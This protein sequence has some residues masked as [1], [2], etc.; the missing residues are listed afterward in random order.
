MGMGSSEPGK[1]NH[2]HFRGAFVRPVLLVYSFLG[3]LGTLYT[4]FTEKHILM[5]INNCATLLLHAVIFTGVV[6]NTEPALRFCRKFIKIFIILYSIAFL[7]MPVMVSS[8]RA[9]GSMTPNTQ[10]VLFDSVGCLF[11]KGEHETTEQPEFDR[12]LDVHTKNQ[13][14]KVFTSDDMKIKVNKL[15]DQPEEKKYI[16]AMVESEKFQDM[17]NNR[18]SSA[19]GYLTNIVFDRM[20]LE[21]KN[22][23]MFKLGMLSGYGMELACLLT[24]GLIYMEYS[25]VKRLWIHS[26]TIMPKED[27]YQ[28]Y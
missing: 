4:C 3:T 24:I 6:Y 12:Q 19:D 14:F 1:D 5:R 27:V 25:L 9:S 20:L 21:I 2:A 10:H 28:Y 13:I 16:L 26:L 11:K 23:E 17:I 15:F 22:Y 8:Y 18:F 7:S